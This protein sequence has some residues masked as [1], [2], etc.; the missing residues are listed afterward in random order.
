MATPTHGRLPAN[1]PAARNEGVASEAELE[2]YIALKLAALGYPKT[3][4]AD[5]EF[6]DIARPL[7]RNYHQKDLMLGNLLCPADRRIQAFLDD[8]LK[9][10]SPAGRRAQIPGN[11][12][13]LDRPGLARVMSLPP[14]S[15]T[16]TSPYLQ[17][18]RVPQGILHNPKSDR[19]T[20]Q[21][22]FH[23][24]EG[25]LPV[26]ADKLAVPKKTFAALLAAAFHP[27]ADLVTLPFSADP[28]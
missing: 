21:G 10:V 15:H 12:F 6:L 13:L 20:T 3:S 9:D 17:S 18:Y 25:G 19:R 14:G 22:I 2:R 26:P 24:V 23:I 7:L 11:T 5:S 27:P 4:Q 16:F 8:Y 1:P 28:G